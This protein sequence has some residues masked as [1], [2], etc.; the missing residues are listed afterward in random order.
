MAY[1]P[2]PRY[3]HPQ[4][5]ENVIQNVEE[6]PSEGFKNEIKEYFAMQ[7][8][9]QANVKAESDKGTYNVA[10]LYTRECLSP[11]N[12]CVNPYYVRSYANISS[13]LNF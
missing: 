1:E 2:Q 7:G 11:Q 4:F 10:T 8:G 3:M 13:T 12:A 5:S 9:L 6:E